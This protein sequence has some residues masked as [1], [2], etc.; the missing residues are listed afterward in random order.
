MSRAIDPRYAT[1]GLSRRTGMGGTML[2]KMSAALAAGFI[3]TMLLSAGAEAQTVVCKMGQKAC[4]TR[5][6]NPLEGE[7]CNEGNLV[8]KVGQKVCGT[9]CYSPLKG[10]SCNMRTK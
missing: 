7:S 10:E 6:Y 9:R 2:R 1:P 8:C 5:C 3:G 4:G